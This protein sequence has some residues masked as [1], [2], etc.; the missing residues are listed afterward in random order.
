MHLHPAGVRK[1]WSV[2]P[3][4]DRSG[5]LSAPNERRPREWTVRS[6]R[7]QAALAGASCVLLMAA[8]V[9][10]TAVAERIPDSGY[11]LR[12]TTAVLGGP[13]WVGSVSRFI[14][15]LWAATATVN[16]LAALLSPPA[17]RRPQLCLGVLIGVLAVDDSLLLHDAALTAQGVPESLILAGY[18]VAGLL[19]AWAWRPVWRT[20]TGLAFFGGVTLLGM[21]VALDVVF[22]DLYVVEDGAKLLGVLAWLLCGAWAFSHAAR[23]TRLEAPAAR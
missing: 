14:N 15:L 18:G 16:V 20:P 8:V 17:H 19:L 11:L 13:W 6:R 22:S 3:T 21:S 7:T 12:D 2:L 5:P 10:V 1:L 23:R 4:T 9:T